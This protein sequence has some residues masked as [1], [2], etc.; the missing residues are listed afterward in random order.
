VDPAG[1]DRVA[2]TLY[3]PSATPLHRLHP[4]TRL[5]GLVA[6]IVAA[7]LVERPLVLAPLLVAMLALVVAAGGAANLRRF[8]LMFL[9]VF[10]FTLLVWTFFYGTPGVPTRAG[11]LFGLSTAVRLSTFLAA[12]LAFLTTTRVEE[13]AYALGWLRVP[14]P[15]RSEPLRLPYKVGFTMVLA[16]RLVPVFFD[17]ALSVVQAQRC[18]GLPMSRGGPLTRLRRFV[19]VIVPVFIGGL[20]RAD[21]MAMALELRGFNSGRPR[22]TYLRARLAPRD[23]VAGAIAAAVLAA[24]VVLWLFGAGALYLDTPGG[25]P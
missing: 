15:F 9:L 20:R 12:G 21:R 17:A 22:T 6:V 13:I 19:P 1:E 10:V 18:R 7:F 24:Y 3:V 16:F 14:V 23:A 25:G 8:R 11:L 2:L 5:W 4:V